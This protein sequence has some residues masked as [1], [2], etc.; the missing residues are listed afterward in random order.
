MKDIYK[1]RWFWIL[2]GLILLTAIIWR[3]NRKVDGSKGGILDGPSH[4]N[5][6]IKTR[7]K[8]TGE[9][10]EVQG[11]EDILTAE[12]NNIKDRYVCEGT[13]GGIA[14]ELNIIGGG[15]KFADDGNCRIK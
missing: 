12:V 14:S 11:G 4:E 6:G 10:V 3:S 2:V 5:G 1:K 15:V 8:S 7:I 13:P 9:I